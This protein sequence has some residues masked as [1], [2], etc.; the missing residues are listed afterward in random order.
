MGVILTK[1]IK[2]YIFAPF[3]IF[4]GFFSILLFQNCSPDASFNQDPSADQTQTLTPRD[5]EANE[6][7]VGGSFEIVIQ[8][9]EVPTDTTVDN[10]DSAVDYVVTV[11]GGSV[12]SIN[13]FFDGN[14]V[15]CSTTDRIPIVNPGLGDHS[16]QIQVVDNGGNQVQEV[17]EWTVYQEIR[18]VSKDISVTTRGDAV[19][20]IINVDNSGSMEYEQN[21]MA[22]R[23]ANFMQ[24]FQDQD[25]HIAITTTS[26]SSNTWPSTLNYVDGKF[27]PLNANEDLFCIKK[28]DRT[29]AEDQA[30]ISANVQRPLTLKDQNGN[31]V[32]GSNGDPLAEGNGWERGIFTTYLAVEKHASNY[33]ANRDCLRDGVA[34]HVII[35]SD[36]RETTFNENTFELFVENPHQI[37]K[38]DGENLISLMQSQ[39]GAE[40]IFKFHS[41]IVDPYTDEGRVC[42]DTHGNKPGIEY[43]DLSLMTGG[44]IG[45][46]CADDYAT[47][48]GAI[49]NIVSNSSL[50]YNLDCIAV[51]NNGEMGSVIDKST[52]QPINVGFQIGGNKVEFAQL[53]SQGEYRVDYYCYQ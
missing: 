32:N 13:C 25:Y 40:T 51:A 30:L 17:I 22:E 27:V 18:L 44:Y 42:L 14:P 8:F 16:F 52:G 31:D 48:L 15:A 49:G 1:F 43:A 21:R 37:S 28:G 46:I 5:R 3:L 47:Q 33:V 29:I 36:E 26:P 24:P 12:Q 9:N 35:I 6:I 50:S 11:P 20:I 7:A 19:D 38:S 4:L 39:F 45:S 41:I 10:S 23:I 34:K 2:Q 53:L